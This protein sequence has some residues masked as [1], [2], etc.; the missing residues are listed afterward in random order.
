VASILPDHEFST[1]GVTTEYLFP[2]LNNALT[3]VL[4]SK[5]LPT[6]TELVTFCTHIFKLFLQLFFIVR[7]I[8]SVE[9]KTVLLFTFFNFH[10]IIYRVGGK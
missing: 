5:E 1:S 9:V 3:L 4:R 2:A 6:F 7:L 8:D 10:S